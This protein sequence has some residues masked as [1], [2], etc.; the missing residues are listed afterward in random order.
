[1]N[2]QPANEVI[3]SR[4]KINDEQ[5]RFLTEYLSSKYGLRTP[6]EKRT[7]LES[8]LLSRLTTL[9]LAN[10]EAYLKYTFNPEAANDEYLFFVDQLTTHKTFFYRE[11]YQFDFLKTILPGYVR[12]MG[13]NHP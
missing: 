9:K 7:L 3:S 8:R 11:N 12:T 1:M 2:A 5:F 4:G 10:I 13:T 6:P